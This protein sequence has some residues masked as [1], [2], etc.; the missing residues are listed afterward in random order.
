MAKSELEIVVKGKDNASPVLKGITGNIQNMS[1]QIRNAGIAMVAFGTA[2]TGGMAT[3]VKA[4]ATAGDEVQKMSLRTKWGTESLS[5]LSY[6]AKISGTDL[7]AFEKGTRKLNKSI[8]DAAD[9]LE[10]YIRDFDKLGLSATALK[11]MKSED[12][13]WAVASALSEVDN[14]VTQSALA[15]NLFGRTGTQLFPLLAEGAEGMEAL[16]KEAHTL[17]IIFDQEAADAAAKLMDRLTTL[18]GGINGVKNA[19]AGALAPTLTSLLEDNIIPVVQNVIKWTEENPKLTETIVKVT[20]AIG[21]TGL[22]GGLTLLATFMMIK[23]I[24]AIIATVIAMWKFVVAT[25]AAIAATGPWGIAIAG[26]SLAFITGG[27]VLGIQELT[28]EINTN[29]DALGEQGD[30]IDANAAAQAKYNRELAAYLDLLEKQKT[31]VGDG[32]GFAA[33]WTRGIRAG[34]GRMPGNIMAEY[35]KMIAGQANRYYEMAGGYFKGEGYSPEEIWG[36]EGYNTLQGPSV[37]PTIEVTIDGEVVGRVASQ[38][39]G[40]DLAS[41]QEV[42]G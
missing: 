24:P 22:L 18:E 13:F 21:I 30:A 32:G 41:R 35:E 37:I 38:Y 40:A 17:G 31:A 14:E 8:V 2:V 3:S 39:M 28:K 36:P 23:M 15:L 5:E 27:V 33:T 19:I 26:L 11:D 10:T 20:A 4:W 34:A 7:N 1:G 42:G 16:R 29:T 25:L 9:G 6:A 12:A